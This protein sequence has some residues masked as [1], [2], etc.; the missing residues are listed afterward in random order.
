MGDTPVS[1]APVSAGVLIM[2]TNFQVM[3][4]AMPAAAAAAASPTPAIADGTVAA[5]V[6][7][8][9][10][11]FLTDRDTL[12]A[13]LPPGKNLSIHGAP[14]VTV[15]AVYQGALAWLAGRGYN[16]ILVSL[17]VVH[18]GRGGRTVGGFLPV[19]WENMA[20]P[21]LVGRETLGWPKIYADLP[22]LRRL[23]GGAECLAAWH[24]FTF[25]EINVSGLRPVTPAELQARGAGAEPSAGQICHKFILRTGS[26]AETDADYLTLS[27]NEGAHA[28]VLKSA[29]IGQA[30]L[31]FHRGSWAQLP[32]MNHVVDALA[33]LPIHQT[34]D[35]VI[36]SQSG[37]S[38]G[39][40]RILE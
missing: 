39:T 3:A 4:R 6:T 35:A 13:M 5:D 8:V 12:A 29:Q 33:A 9:S 28:P 16:L 19:V 36:V 38:M 1:S 15:T 2:P 37:G 7:A 18:E 25:L 20:E 10:V 17:P 22:P 24:G 14:V 34:Y 11:S 26:Y 21:I 27:G 31:R 23:D 40:T 30:S 32:T